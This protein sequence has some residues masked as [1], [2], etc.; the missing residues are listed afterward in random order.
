MRVS[1]SQIFDQGVFGMQSNQTALYRIMNQL[2]SGRRI[3]TPEDDPVGAAQALLV[4][5]SKQVNALQLENQATA[6]T[7]LNYLE[8]NLASVG[9]ELQ[10]I[11]ERAV[12]GGNDTLGTDDRKMI[13]TEL[14]ARLDNLMSL[15]NAQDGTGN[16]LYS[17]FQTKEKPFVVNST[18]PN[19]TPLVSP[20]TAAYDMLSN[21]SVSYAGDDGRRQLQVSS[22]VDMDINAPGSDVFMRVRDSSG[23]VTQRSVFDAVNNLINY[24]QQPATTAPRAD[25]DQ[26]LKDLQSSLDNVLEVR[27]S[28]GARLNQLDSLSNMGEDFGLQYDQRLSELQDVDYA[29]AIS[30]L[31][32]RQMQLEAAQASFSKISG[33]NLFN[34]L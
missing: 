17:G 4:S 19:P 10:N 8:S 34:Y 21:S 29:K 24:M 31:S 1:S 11:F 6:R 27:S 15:A 33:L 12:Q 13:A 14:K 26:A 25:Y 9:G 32:R 30:D 2:S 20:A 28:V 7:Q 18:T 3:L 23:A 5:Q 22:S 16:Y